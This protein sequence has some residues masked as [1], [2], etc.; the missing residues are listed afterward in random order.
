M[1]RKASIIT[2][3]MEQAER[4]CMPYRHGAI[5]SKGSKIVVKGFN[6]NRSKYMN[7]CYSS[8]HAEMDVIK[9]YCENILH[10]NIDLR[11]NKIKVPKISRYTLWVVRISKSNE[12]T[13]YF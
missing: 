2:S 12:L 9:Q 13:Y 7:V 3:A 10:L 1:A 6:R 5:L 8:I 11:K 4:S